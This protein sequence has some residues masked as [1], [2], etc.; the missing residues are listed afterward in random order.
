MVVGGGWCGG[1]PIGSV[2]NILLLIVHS[3]LRSAVQQ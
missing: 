2:L 1:H 3:A